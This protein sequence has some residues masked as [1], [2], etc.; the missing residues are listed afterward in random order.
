MDSQLAETESQSGAGRA[1][2][3]YVKILLWVVLGVL[4]GLSC[5]A[6]FLAY[7]QPGMLLEQMNL[8]YCG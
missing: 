1:P 5:V 8:R 2:R 6:I 4:I 3:P 7:G